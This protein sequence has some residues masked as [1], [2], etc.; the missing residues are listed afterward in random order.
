MNIE[1]ERKIIKQSRSKY[2]GKYV[3][4][5]WFTKYGRYLKEHKWNN[6]IVYRPYK[7]KI[8][9]YNADK[10]FTRLVRNKKMGIEYLW[11]A[12]E[13]DRDTNWTHAHL[14]TNGICDLNKKD[15]ASTLKRSI[16]EIKYLSTPNNS[17]AVSHYCSKYIGIG[18]ITGYG[19][20]FKN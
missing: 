15:I 18:D 17:D 13:K 9:E 20:V 1:L 8:T 3:Q 14:L 10:L 19:F 5:T 4:P 6:I 2:N 16:S 7:C 12:L 11:Y